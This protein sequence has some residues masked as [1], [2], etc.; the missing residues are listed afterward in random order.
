[1]H[2]HSE[3]VSFFNQHNKWIKVVQAFP[4]YDD[5]KLRTVKIN[6]LFN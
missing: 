2:E 1:M 6:W 3:P 4:W 5:W